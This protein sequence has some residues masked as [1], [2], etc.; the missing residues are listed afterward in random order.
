M[1]TWTSLAWSSSAQSTANSSLGV[2]ISP[3]S[4]MSEEATTE[5]TP[6][7]SSFVAARS[8]NDASGVPVDIFIS[9]TVLQDLMQLGA[10]TVAPRASTVRCRDRERLTGRSADGMSLAPE[11]TGDFVD[12]TVSLSTAWRDR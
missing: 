12:V 1:A 9:S 7:R 8:V 3:N 11:L 2:S 5:N 10:Y 4:R 6:S